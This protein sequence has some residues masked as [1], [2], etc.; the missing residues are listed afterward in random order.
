M[1]REEKIDAFAM[2]LDGF[3]YEEIGQKYGMSKERVRQIF[4]N[5]TAESGIARKNYIFPNI[6]DWMVKNKVNQYYFAKK[7]GTTQTTISAILTGKHNPSF[8]FI[9]CVLETTGMTYEVAF[10]KERKEDNEE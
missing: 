2:R 5:V 9:Q 8:K 1:T 3:T 10:S 6:R 4:A 7:L